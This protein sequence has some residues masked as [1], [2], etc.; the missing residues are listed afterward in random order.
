MSLS[1]GSEHCS[2]KKFSNI[3]EMKL[4]DELKNKRLLT[5][6]LRGS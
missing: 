6:I 3:K 1:E 5:K 4:P 2:R